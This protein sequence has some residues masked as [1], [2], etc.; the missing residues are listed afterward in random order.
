MRLEIKVACFVA[1]FF[2][3]SVIGF[4][5]SYSVAATYSDSE[6]ETLGIASETPRIEIA[7][8]TA[9][10][11]FTRIINDENATK[12]WNPGGYRTFFWIE[13]PLVD[14]MRSTVVLNTHSV[15]DSLCTADYVG[16]G[17]FGV[18]C[19]PSYRPADGTVLK[20]TVVNAEVLPMI[21]TEINEEIAK[22]TENATGFQN[23]T[24][25]SGINQTNTTM[26]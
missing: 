4:S 13:D 6:T 15:K 7:S 14:S 16:L 11:I 5:Q 17:G 22:K 12:G 9:P 2:T 1:I 25:V 19:S 21:S 10:Q 20:Y 8:T 23:L 18:F 26:R 24:Q 3:V